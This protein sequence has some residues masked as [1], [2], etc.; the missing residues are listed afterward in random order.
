MPD[1]S[2]SFTTVSYLHE[3]RIWFLSKYDRGRFI[4][5]RTFA[6]Y[7]DAKAALDNGYDE[8]I[9][10]GEDVVEVILAIA[11]AEK[12][13]RS[14]TE[15]PARPQADETSSLVVDMPK[16]SRPQE[17]MWGWLET[18]HLLEI[19]TRND[20]FTTGTRIHVGKLNTLRSLVRL[21]LVEKRAIGDGYHHKVTDYYY[22]KAA[23]R[24]E[25]ELEISMNEP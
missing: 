20:V 12:A 6:S 15:P 11:Q 19:G 9:D 14:K 10:P 23:V 21:G 3:H 17:E 16:L 7:D 8:W 25:D 4:S 24:I 2:T 5:H 13:T 22:Q 18:G 1:S